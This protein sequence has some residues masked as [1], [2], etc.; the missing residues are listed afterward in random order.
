MS[1]SSTSPKHPAGQRLESTEAKRQ[2]T[3]EGG[4]AGSKAED[5]VKTADTGAAAAGSKEA[6][7][8]AEVQQQPQSEAAI[9]VTFTVSGDAEMCEASKL[10]MAGRESREVVAPTAMSA[11]E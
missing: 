2:R 11:G 9:A 1:T 6:Q 4:A 3:G 7:R 8:G 5:E 10:E